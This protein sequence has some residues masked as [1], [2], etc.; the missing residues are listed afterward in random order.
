[1]PRRPSSGGLPRAPFGAVR[2]PFV[3]F[4]DASLGPPLFNLTIQ[5]CLAGLH[6]AIAGVPVRPDFPA[7]A[8]ARPWLGLAE[9]EGCQPGW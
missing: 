3:P 2:T 4:R 8:Q 9:R 5:H 1:M 6:K 7:R